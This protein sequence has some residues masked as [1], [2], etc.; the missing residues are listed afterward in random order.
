MAW[1]F[2]RNNKADHL[3]NLKVRWTEN[4]GMWRLR[5]N[6][7]NVLN[8]HVCFVFLTA[9]LCSNVGYAFVHMER[10][11]EAMAAI[12][13]LNGTMFKGRQLAVEL[14]KAQPL[15]NQMV[16]GGNSTGA[17]EF[18]AQ[19]LCI[20]FA[21]A[22]TYWCF[23]FS[24]KVGFSRDPPCPLSIRARQR[25]LLQL[26]QL[27]PDCPYRSVGSSAGLLQYLIS[28]FGIVRSCWGK[29]ISKHLIFFNPPYILCL[30]V[31]MMGFVQ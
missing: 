15:V 30:F 8:Y 21:F 3:I 27:R 18:K 1:F 9:R 17:E 5:F 25:F 13:A 31:S 28:I 14:S 4:K 19:Y 10:K 24:M 26:Q 12:D 29:I 20:S 2:C 11:E 22:N 23:S 7:R 16:S 6:K